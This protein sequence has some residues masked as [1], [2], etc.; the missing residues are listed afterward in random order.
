[1]IIVLFWLDFQLCAHPPSP[2]R[3]NIQKS[4]PTFQCGVLGMCQADC[5]PF[6]LCILLNQTLPTIKLP[7]YTALLWTARYCPYSLKAGQ[8]GGVENQGEIE[9]ATQVPLSHRAH[10]F[11]TYRVVQTPL[12]PTLVAEMPQFGSSNLQ[13][14]GLGTK[15]DAYVIDRF[16]EALPLFFIF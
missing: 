9:L 5:Q 1:M 13:M 12:K 10:G 16:W 14:Q 8:A 2:Q 4:I 6:H 15:F 3:S 11:H 7:L